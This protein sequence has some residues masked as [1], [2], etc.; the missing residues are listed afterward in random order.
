MQFRKRSNLSPE[1]QL[2][3]ARKRHPSNQP[4]WDYGIFNIIGATMVQPFLMERAGDELFEHGVWLFTVEGTALMESAEG[5]IILEPGTL[6]C[7][8]GSLPR[9]VTL[10][11]DRWVRISMV[12][13]MD[14]ETSLHRPTAPQIITFPDTGRISNA[15]GGLL[16]E[17]NPVEGDHEATSLY[18]RL[19]LRYVK[20]ASKALGEGEDDELMRRF[21]RLW[22]NVRANLSKKWTIEELASQ[23]FISD[24]YL[25]QIC[26]KQFETSPLQ[27]V[28]HLRMEHAKELLAN[29]SLP[30]Q[31]VAEMVGYQ[32]DYAFSN[33][34]VKS[35]GKRPGGYRQASRES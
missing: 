21:N 33:A 18:A 32:S 12:T 28:K 35:T 24:S 17:Q 16:E 23:M 19:I 1:C 13:R 31:T 6:C 10:L 20:R 2:R 3:F 4:L 27:Y 29:T 26:R 34:F 14:A 11:T 7:T 8:P 9:R 22:G 30:L 25:H 5:D 15:V